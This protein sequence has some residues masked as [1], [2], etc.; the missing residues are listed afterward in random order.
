VMNRVNAMFSPPETPDT[1]A[2]HYEN[3]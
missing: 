1:A 2:L 3:P